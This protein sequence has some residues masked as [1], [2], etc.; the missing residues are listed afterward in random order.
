MAYAGTLVASGRGKGVVVATGDATEI[1]RI[2]AMLSE[3]STLTTPLLQQI[4]R[5]SRCADRC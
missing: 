5:F 1:G 3:V 2:S 4:A